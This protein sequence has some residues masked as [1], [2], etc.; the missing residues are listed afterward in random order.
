MPTDNACPICHSGRM[1]VSYRA[2][3]LDYSN[4][5]SFPILVCTHCGYGRTE[6]V[7]QQTESL[8]VGGC[9]DEK[10]KP[11]HKLIRPLLSVLEHGKLRYLSSAKTAG[12]KLLEI[13]CGKG[14]FLEAARER[15][16]QI[17]GI[18][19]SPRS[20][21]FASARLG[22]AVAPVGLEEV[23]KVSAFPGEYDYVML[24]HVL[25]HLDDPAAVLAGIRGKLVDDGRLVIAVPNFASFQARHGGGDWYHLDPPR[26]VH[27]FT[28]DSL[29]ILS[30]EKGYVVEKIL[31][32]SLYQNYVGEIVTMVN[33]L[34]PGKNV[35][36]NG[37]RLN[38]TYLDRF[39]RWKAWG[40]FLSGLFLSLAIALP[41]LLLTLF[42][43]LAG[44]S[45]TMVVVMKPEAK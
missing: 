34:L 32:D 44:R 3:P 41:M 16:F 14:R 28:P 43:Q 2:T 4:A 9:Y 6:I 45:G 17:Y 37:L 15:G 22:D 40:L 7:H 12:K 13:G 10:E 29:R 38:R 33:K 21:A 1:N 19:P 8:Y 27:H 20:Y 35:V 42:N 31:F 23:H 39:G 11:W 26:H 5:H 24:W 18:E 30:G 36:F 25:E